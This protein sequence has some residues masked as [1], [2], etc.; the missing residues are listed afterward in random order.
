MPAWQVAGI[1]VA[2]GVVLVTLVIVYGCCWV[3]G[4]ADAAAQR[5]SEL[6]ASLDFHLLDYQHT[7]VDQRDP[8]AVEE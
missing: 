2:G 5:R 4:G 8:Q 7:V 6:Q 1:V 3:S